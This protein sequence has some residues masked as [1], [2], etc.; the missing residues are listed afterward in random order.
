MYCEVDE[1]SKYREGRE[2]WESFKKR[3]EKYN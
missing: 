1:E 2:E 3:R